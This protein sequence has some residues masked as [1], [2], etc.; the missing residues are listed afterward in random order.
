MNK[1]FSETTFG[2]EWESLLLN[3]NLALPE[4]R[5]TREFANNVRS[6]VYGSETGIDHIHRLS[7]MLEIRP[8]ILRNTGELRKCTE[9]HIKVIYDECEKNKFLF[10]PC[11]THPALGNAVGL[12]VHI[13]TLYDSPDAVR[14]ANG[15]IR[16][17]PC[18]AALSANSPV[19]GN[20]CYEYKS[21]RLLHHAQF[22]SVTRAAIPPEL[23]HWRWA[24]DISITVAFHSTIEL[25][26]GDSASSKEFV[27]EYVTFVVAFF[28]GAIYELDLKIDKKSYE[29]YIIN[30]WRASKYGLQSVFKWN[31][32]S[33]PVVEILKEMLKISR[34][35]LIEAKG[36]KL[37]PKMIEKHQTQADWQMR[38]YRE[39]EDP[40]A[41][42]RFLI[43][44]IKTGDP[45]VDY[46]EKTDV[47]SL[48][49]PQPIEDYILS[50][51]D[52]D[53]PYT[54][55]YE[56]L[57]IPYYILDKYLDNLVKSGKIEIKCDPRYG[58]RFT[59][60]M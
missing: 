51:I 57:L 18:F 30:R 22:C 40:F 53:T 29:E 8:I 35:N 34:F 21:Y 9:D 32:K 38:I 37:I 5:D 6:R 52:K 46:I 43:D 10:L 49:K 16:Y 50:Y 19:Y 17:I 1:R 23:A 24:E 20:L 27:N 48:S 31:G 14:I 26:I 39:I 45:F 7:P 54:L 44:L 60:C 56:L 47:L 36:L 33:V 25:R 59:K 13:G 28:L 3:Q 58:K 41:Y 11:G 55:L 4:S 12:H 15:L 2:Y 42:T